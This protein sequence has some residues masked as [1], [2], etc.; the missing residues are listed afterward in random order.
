[1]LTEEDAAAPRF[2]LAAV[3]AAAAA[4]G[5]SVAVFF[6]RFGRAGVAV[7]ASAAD[8][9][10]GGSAIGDAARFLPRVVFF[11]TGASP[12]TSIATGELMVG[13]RLW[14]VCTR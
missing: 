14:D 6:A 10:V 5:T 7:V 9:A 1:M 8:A 3:V 12:D 4:A 2:D 13:E 11:A